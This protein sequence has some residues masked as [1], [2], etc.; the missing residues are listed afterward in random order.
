MRLHHAFLLVVSL[1]CLA[2]TLAIQ[3][4]TNTRAYRQDDALKLAMPQSPTAAS[5]SQ[6]PALGIGLFDFIG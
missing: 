5:K 3:V 4:G 6:R 1:G 2:Y